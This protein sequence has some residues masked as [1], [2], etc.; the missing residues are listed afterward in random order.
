MNSDIEAVNPVYAPQS[1]NLGCN[2][3]L[4]R[5]MKRI[6]EWHQRHRQ[7]DQLMEL[8]PWMLK[9]IGISRTD[10]IREGSKPFWRE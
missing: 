4:K 5:V 8:S 1:R 10:A 7:R 6:V 3:L 2:R 9:D